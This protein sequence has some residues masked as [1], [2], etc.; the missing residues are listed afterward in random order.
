MLIWWKDI[1]S[2]EK[3]VGSSWF[4]GEVFRRIGNGLNNNFLCDPWLENVSLS[5]SFPRLFSL[6]IQKEAK[7]GEMW[8]LIVGVQKRTSGNGYI[9][10]ICIQ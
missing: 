2:L 1:A 10:T 9:E 5:V 8:E 7:M 6:S 4:N 3:S